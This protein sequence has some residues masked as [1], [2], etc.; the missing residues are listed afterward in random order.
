[1]FDNAPNTDSLSATSMWT[2]N[3][4]LSRVR[5]AILR[6]GSGNPRARAR[7]DVGSL[8][9]VLVHARAQ[10][11]RALQRFVENFDC[12]DTERTMPTQKSSPK[13]SENIQERISYRVCTANLR[14]H[15]IIRCTVASIDLFSSHSGDIQNGFYQKCDC[16]QVCYGS[17]KNDSV[18][19]FQIKGRMWNSTA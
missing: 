6:C 18:R 19:H 11:S 7:N 15:D 12:R 17:K 14:E 10:C 4:M 8:E 13:S 16:R 1:M 2:M 3:R 9:C 5:C